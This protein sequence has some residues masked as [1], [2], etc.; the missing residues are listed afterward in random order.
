VVD[1]W[2]PQAD[3][4]VS[5]LNV[6]GSS[7][8]VGGTYAHISGADRKGI[9]SYSIPN[10]TLDEWVPMIDSQLSNVSA[11]AISGS[12]IFISESFYTSLGTLTSRIFAFDR[13][14]AVPLNWTADLAVIRPQYYSTNVSAIALSARGV[15]VGGVF[16]TA[17][18]VHRIGIAGFTPPDFL[19]HDG[20]D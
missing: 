16:D 4:L 15:L 1:A 5:E 7:L 2:N 10:K 3:G 6:A 11:I 12:D 8:Y 9:S 18:G 19:F 13:E 14:T 20:F 17:A